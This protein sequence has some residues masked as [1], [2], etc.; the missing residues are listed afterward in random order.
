MARPKTHG[1]PISF[2]LPIEY[3]ELLEQRAHESGESTA[4]YVRRNIMRALDTKRR[5][6]TKAKPVT[7]SLARDTVT[8]IPKTPRKTAARKVGAR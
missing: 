3:D 2:R 7:K 1:S 5:N 6:G 4:E 8:P